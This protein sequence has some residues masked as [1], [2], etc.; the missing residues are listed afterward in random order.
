MILEWK[1]FKTDSPDNGTEPMKRI[2]T[3]IK[4]NDSKGI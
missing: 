1:T 2:L 4:K 3:N